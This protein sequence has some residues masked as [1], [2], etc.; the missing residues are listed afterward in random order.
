L[1]GAARLEY[2]KLEKPLTQSEL[3]EWK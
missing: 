2:E 1:L 3:G